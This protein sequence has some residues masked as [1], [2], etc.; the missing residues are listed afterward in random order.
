LTDTLEYFPQESYPNINETIEV[1]VILPSLNEEHTISNCIDKIKKVFEKNDI[2]GEII[3]ADNSI[4]NTPLVAEKHGAFVITPEKNGYGYAYKSAFRYMKGDYIVIG[5]ADDTYDFSEI[6]NL[7]KPLRNDEAD[8]VIG[9]RLKGNIEKDAMPWHHKNIGNPALTWFLNLFFKAGVSDA[10][11]G[12]RAI[13]KDYLNL[14]NLDSDGME[15]ASE[16]IIEA[17][18]KGLRIKEVPISYSKRKINNSKLRSFSDGWRHLKFM[19]QNAPKFLYIYPGIFLLF[20]GLFLFFS[21]FLNLNI[22]YLPG[23]HSMIAGSLLT[24]TGYQVILFGFFANIYMKR[25]FP[26]FFSL[27]KGATIG[28]LLFLLGSVY[29]FILLWNWIISGFQTLPSLEHDVFGFTLLVLGLQ[30][31][32]SSFMLSIIANGKKE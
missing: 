4:D 1:T 28:S 26:R 21:A 20:V 22:G 23:I 6:P 10:H 12:F 17:A 19:L 15:F 27:E 16:M 7:L 25:D 24:I 2:R 5:D 13:K 31:F 14:L 9:N 11:S 32:F 18:K 8:L 3:V 30:T 29:V